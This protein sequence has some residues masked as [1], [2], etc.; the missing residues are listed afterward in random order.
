[1]SNLPFVPSELASTPGRGILVFAS[2]DF[3]HR[4]D[5]TVGEFSGTDFSPEIV[6]PIADPGSSMDLTLRMVKIHYAAAQ[7][8]LVEVSASGTG[9]ESWDE[10]QSVILPGTTRRLQELSLG[11]NVTGFDLLIRIRFLSPEVALIYKIQPFLET[12]SEEA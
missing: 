11:F 5:E 12:T 1:M 3:V 10:T 2:S 9:G 8:S 4:V 6:L 7:D